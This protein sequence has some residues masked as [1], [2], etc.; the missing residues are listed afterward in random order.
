MTGNEPAARLPGNPQG[1]AD[2]SDT[3]PLLDVL[4]SVDEPSV[5]EPSVDEPEV[6]RHALARPVPTPPDADREAGPDE[7]ELFEALV[8]GPTT[9]CALAEPALGPVPEPAPGPAP[10][11]GAAPTT[12]LDALFYPESRQSD[13]VDQT[14]VAPALVPAPVPATPLAPRAGLDLDPH[15]P[16]K[17][18]WG[19]HVLG[20]LLGLAVGPVGAV[21]LLLGQ[22]RLLAVQTDRWDLGSGLV[23]S[24]VDIAGI[25]LVLVS[26][27]V[28]GALVLAAIWTAAAP[29]TGGVV[30]TAVG[31]WALVAPGS[32]GDVVGFGSGTLRTTVSQTIAAGTSGTLLT[33]GLLLLAAG[34]AA[35]AARRAGVRLGTFEGRTR[36]R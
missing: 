34:I 13:P 28:L 33:V 10:E 21:G 3:I 29:L 5:D 12:G 36:S 11:P 23:G 9:G 26:A 2:Q 6:G 7:P 1:A 32:F 8:E 19:T 20:V 15:P 17:A 35:A 24:D 27:L 18:G 16:T 4:P 22:S 31:G 14:A 25:A 30:A